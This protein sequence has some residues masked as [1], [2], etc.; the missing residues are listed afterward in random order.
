M[1]RFDDLEALS[2][3]APRNHHS[4]FGHSPFGHSPFGHCRVGCSCRSRSA[5]RPARPTH[6]DRGW[7]EHGNH[8]VRAR[9]DASIAW[10]SRV[11]QRRVELSPGLRAAVD[12]R[13]PDHVGGTQAH[14]FGHPRRKSDRFRSTGADRGAAG[15]R[16]GMGSRRRRGRLHSASSRHPLHRAGVDGL[17]SVRRPSVGAPSRRTRHRDRR[18]DHDQSARRTSSGCRR[19]H[20]DYRG[21][22]P[23]HRA[24]G[25]GRQQRLD[26]SRGWPDIS[27]ISGMPAIT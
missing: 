22:P 23:R 10:C 18:G 7:G 26:H 14:W 16:R 12:D 5:H 6:D 25:G 24:T 2:M 9:G 19:R 13:R 17:D 21:D 1:F 20:C 11:E 27:G 15:V 4:P 8:P 3:R